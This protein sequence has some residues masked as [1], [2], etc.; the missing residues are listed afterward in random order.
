MTSLG[1]KSL[2]QQKFGAAAADYAT[3][4]VHARG[5]SLGRLVE[6][7]APEKRWRV[8]DVA[9][10]AGHTALALAPHV[11]KV[12]ASDIT[13]AMLAEAKKLATA[14]GLGNV[15]TV[16]AK[17]EDLPF[18]DMSFDLVTCRLAAHH[19]TDVAAFAAEAYRV[20][21]PNGLLAVVD[22]ISPDQEIFPALSAEDARHWTEA[23]N[24]FEKLRDPSH[25][26]CLSLSAW[27][28]VLGKTGFD[29]VAA[30]H[31]DQD[32][33]F[34]PWVTR[35]RC[36]EATM[37]QLRALLHEQPLRDLLKPRDTETGTVFTLQEGIMVARKPADPS[38]R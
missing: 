5:E 19:F 34:G 37:A 8:L 16:P 12:T 24:A 4:T 36:D 22:N 30:E 14:R 7:V 18:P 1:T 29:I 32:L 25:G 35:M 20:L 27:R 21:M 23:Y 9:T 28:D 33:E 26:H 2:A 13:E 11:A 31:V 15:K 3:S 17:A 10:G 38:S 6:L